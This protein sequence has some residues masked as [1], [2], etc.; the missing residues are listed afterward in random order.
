MFFMPKDMEGSDWAIE[1]FLKLKI[2]TNHILENQMAYRYGL[3]DIYE[4]GYTKIW[5]C[6][7]ITT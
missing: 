3:R 2:T 7:S 6:F 5:R 1:I 4:G